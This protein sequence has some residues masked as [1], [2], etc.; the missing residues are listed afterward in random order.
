[1]SDIITAITIKN[2]AREMV[3]K[4][5]AKNAVPEYDLK[6]KGIYITWKEPGFGTLRG[7][8]LH[9]YP[10]GS[11]EVRS[12]QGGYYKIK[13]ADVLSKTADF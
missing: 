8:V 9:K 4:A 5:T 10:D 6:D 11:V 1:M 2:M 7:L 3:R 13:R 12:A